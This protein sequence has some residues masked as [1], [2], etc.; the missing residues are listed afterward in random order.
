MTKKLLT[1]ILTIAM[2][3]AVFTGCD[4]GA[5]SENTDNISPGTS[6]SET[7]GD[8][9]SDTSDTEDVTTQH[10]HIIDYSE[11]YENFDDTTH[12][13]VCKSCGETVTEKHI[14][15][16]LYN[17]S[18]HYYSCICQYDSIDF[19]EHTIE[20]GK[21][22]VCEYT[23]DPNHKHN[24]T[25]Y[26][27]EG[28]AGHTKKCDCGKNVREEH[29]RSELANSASG[30][31]YKCACDY[32][33]ET[34]RHTWGDDG[35]CSVCG[36]QGHVCKY[37][38]TTYDDTYHSFHCSECGGVSTTTHS[39]YDQK[40]YLVDGAS[41]Y[42]KCDYCDYKLTERHSFDNGCFIT[43][44][45]VT[46]N[47]PVTSSTGLEF[48]LH[49]GS[50]TLVGIGN[51]KDT[52]IVVPGS[53]KGIPVTAVASSAFEG[54]KKIV[55]VK[56]PESITD[57]GSSAFSGCTALKAIN[58][59]LN[60]TVIKENTFSVCKSL[61]GVNI[62]ASVKTIEMFAFSGCTSLKGFRNDMNNSSVSTEVF[63]RLTFIGDSAF[64]NCKSLEGN[65]SFYNYEYIG[66]LAFSGCTSV[67]SVELWTIT[68]LGGDAFSNCT[69]LK[70]VSVE[71]EAL[72]MNDEWGFDIGTF[73]GCTSLKKMTMTGVF[74]TWV[75][76]FANS[77]VDEEMGLSWYKGTPDFTVEFTKLNHE[78][79]WEKDKSMKV[80]E[81]YKYL[82]EN[83]WQ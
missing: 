18:G 10:E 33:F 46:C 27:Y 58:I 29:I 45:C 79:E 55:Y 81:I 78:G 39:Y 59:P 47:S 60:V 76:F 26:I 56:L 12:S 15:K 53:V 72:K 64:S 28:T 17:V 9:P 51:C 70:T 41:H 21:C 44:S 38:K 40:E 11:K 80:S 13:Y 34:E 1:F 31:Y 5:G 83:Y 75:D 50:Y 25:E 48:E 74:E 20:N 37:D 3:A 62:P 68:V 14:M 65:L 71:P 6:V 52:H 67:K 7:T 8:I 23:E 82:D 54:N 19:A 69:A 63:T 24:Y 49:N 16:L 57:I 66:N 36:Y 61:I 73:S 32:E 43:D 22:T 2:M 42:K 77:I 35:K 30:H 4:E